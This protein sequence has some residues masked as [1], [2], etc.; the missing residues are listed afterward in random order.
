MKTTITIAREVD[1]AHIRIEAEVRYG[2]EDI[3][4]DFPGRTGD[5]WYANINIDTGKIEGWPPGRAEKMFMTVKD[6]GTY[7]LVDRDGFVIGER[8]DDYVPHGVVPGN[9]GDTIELDIA[10]D[11]TIT[12]WPTKPDVSAFFKSDSE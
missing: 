7:I 6:G 5:R 8:R 2:E 11:G 3:P 12:N 1:I 4:N 10:A 9:Y